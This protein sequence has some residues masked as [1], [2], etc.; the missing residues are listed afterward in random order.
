MAQVLKGLGDPQRLESPAGSLQLLV[1][2]CW[3]P[4]RLTGPLLR[5]GTCT[6]LNL[7]KEAR[8]QVQGRECL[9]RPWAAPLAHHGQ[10]SH[11]LLSLHS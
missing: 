6:L 2:R 7:G 1:P 5:A 4:V 9:P 8:N 10:K 3:P 11:F